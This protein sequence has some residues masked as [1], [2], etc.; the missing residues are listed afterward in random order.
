MG[1]TI[2]NSLHLHNL[3]LTDGQAIVSQDRIAL[4]HMRNKMEQLQKTDNKRQH[5]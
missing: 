4:E 1:I 5:Q 2:S 3:I